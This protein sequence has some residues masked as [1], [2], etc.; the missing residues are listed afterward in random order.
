MWAQNVVLDMASDVLQETLL[1]IVCSQVL[2]GTFKMDACLRIVQVALAHGTNVNAQDAQVCSLPALRQLKQ[3]VAIDDGTVTVHV[4]D[5]T[6]PVKQARTHQAAAACCSACTL[7]Q[8]P[9]CSD[10]DRCQYVMYSRQLPDS[11]LC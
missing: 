7:A 3:S 5:A 10:M 6:L 9:C 11:F 2:L 4:S 1:H 8:L